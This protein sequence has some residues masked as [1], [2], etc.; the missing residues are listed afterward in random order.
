MKPVAV[1]MR[2]SVD[3]VA[4]A[5]LLPFRANVLLQRETHFENL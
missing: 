1:I 3:P 2:L 4:D 5:S